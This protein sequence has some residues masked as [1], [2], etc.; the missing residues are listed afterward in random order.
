[1]NIDISYARGPEDMVHIRD[2]FTEYQKWLGVDLC[3]QDFDREMASL[4]GKYAEPKG[5]LLLARDGDAIAGG[6][7]MWPI[8]EDICEMKRLFVRDPW[9]GQGLG[10]RLAVDII[11]EAKERGYERMCL[12][13]LHHLT[14]AQALYGAL[15]FVDTDPYYDNPLEGVRY[16]E[17]DFAANGTLV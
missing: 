17:L 13:T 6:V 5:C 11:K 16:M 1:M 12:D 8:G 2:L 4:P 10:R 14:A 7:G 9:K 3:F 15:G